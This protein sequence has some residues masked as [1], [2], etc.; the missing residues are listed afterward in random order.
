MLNSQFTT[1]VGLVEFTFAADDRLA[2]NDSRKLPPRHCC[3]SG[4]VRA[5]TK[6]RG[7][8]EETCMETM[9]R[10]DI[11]ARRHWLCNNRDYTFRTICV[12]KHGKCNLNETFD[13]IHHQTV[14][15]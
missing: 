11:A 13:Y 9:K 3:K 15:E 5:D 14:Q 2:R 8:N 12:S 4:S 10:K 1:K 6:E 7:P